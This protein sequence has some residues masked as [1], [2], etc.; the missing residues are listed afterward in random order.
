MEVAIVDDEKVIRGQIK[1]LVVKYE[2]D[3]NVIAYE[4]GE[5]LLAEGKKLDVVFLD[6]QM[7]GMNGIDT[8]RALREKQEDMVVIFITGVKEYV[9]EAFDVSA[10]HYLLKPVEEKKFSEVFERAKK[11]VKKRTTQEQKN[12]FIKNRNRS[13]TINR[14]NILYIENRGKKVEIH[15]GNEIIET[16]ASMN[17][18]EKQLGGNFYRCHRGYLVNMAHIAEYENDSI[19]LNNGENIFMAKERYN[20]FVKEYMR[21][22]RNGGTAGV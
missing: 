5:E 6:I 7:E 22:L 1:K 9:F 13:F 18:L 16:Y 19:S 20:E 12:I 21:Y 11:E 3:C 4:T 8:A 15:T 2:P 14:D 17:D 10:F